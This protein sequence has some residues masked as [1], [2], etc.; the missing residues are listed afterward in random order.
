[1]EDTLQTSGQGESQKTEYECKVDLRRSLR[2]K[3]FSELAAFHV[4]THGDHRY[5]T[6]LEHDDR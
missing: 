5:E 4:S 6:N 2:I 3:Y 1:M